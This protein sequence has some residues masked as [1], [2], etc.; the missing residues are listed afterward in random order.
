MLDVRQTATVTRTDEVQQRR[1]IKDKGE[2]KKRKA[3]SGFLGLL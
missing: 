3:V 2:A 1:K